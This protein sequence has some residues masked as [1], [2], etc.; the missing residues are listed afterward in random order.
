MLEKK[1]INNSFSKVSKFLEILLII[2]I[3]IYGLSCLDFW[4][5]TN[6]NF[7]FFFF[8]LKISFQAFHMSLHFLFGT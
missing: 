2:Y 8:P 4:I 7:Q 3:Y 6:I 1:I 5:H